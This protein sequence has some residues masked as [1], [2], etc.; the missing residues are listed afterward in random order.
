MVCPDTVGWSLMAGTGTGGS[1][2]AGVLCLVVGCGATPLTAWLPPWYSLSQT[3]AP[4]STISLG[5]LAPPHSALLLRI[6]SVLSAPPSIITASATWRCN[7]L[8]K[9]LRMS[10]LNGGTVLSSGCC[11]SLCLTMGFLGSPSLAPAE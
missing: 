10:I 4:T 5:I 11:S 6:R 8:A 7:G 1:A 9:L 3:L 2:V